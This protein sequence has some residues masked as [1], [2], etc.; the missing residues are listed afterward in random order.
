MKKVSHGGDK[1]LNTIKISETKL[2]VMLTKEDM[3]SHHIKSSELDGADP[4]ARAA[5]RELLKEAGRGEGFDCDGGRMF[6]QL[7]PDAE[8][9][10]EI[11]VTFL[12][13][14]TAPMGYHNTD[15][16]DNMP[17]F[18]AVETKTVPV[19]YK[20]SPDIYEF[21]DFEALIAL[22]GRLYKKKRGLFSDG[23][24]S[25]LFTEPERH[26]Y[27]LAVFGGEGCEYIMSEYG[28]ERRGGLSYAYIKEHCVKL[29][30]GDAIEKL[31]SLS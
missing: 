30:G 21:R 26:V 5:L 14:K 22:A 9:G 13:E 6:I 8:G 19:R 20:F 2:K 16:E 29:C 4:R 17:K 11:F 1:G 18:G 31:G 3:E 23:T 15:M 12:A 10:C 25:T 27:Y 24:A 28:G 7:Y